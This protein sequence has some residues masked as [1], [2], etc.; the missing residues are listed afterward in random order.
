[1]LLSV[2]VLPRVG[3]EFAEHAVGGEEHDWLARFRTLCQGLRRVCA[4]CGVIDT[5]PPT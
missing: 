2:G 4:R 3:G 1:M 5:S